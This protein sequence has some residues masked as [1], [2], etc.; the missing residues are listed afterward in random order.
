MRVEW[1]D[2]FD[3]FVQRLEDEG[4]DERLD[5]LAALLSALRGLAT[6]PEQESAT[7]KTVRQ[8]RRHRIWRV[9][10][11]YRQGAALRVLAWFPD[12]DRVVVALI[13][14]DKAGLGDIWYDSAT[15]RAEDEVDRWLRENERQG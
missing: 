5:L 4:N 6:A 2:E 10:H 7:F 12:P 3:R 15:R 9:A 13:G 11:P 1:S 8:A 14:F